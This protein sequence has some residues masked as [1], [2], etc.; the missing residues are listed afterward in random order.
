MAG[1][2][3]IPDT[4]ARHAPPDRDDRRTGPLLRGGQSL[5]TLPATQG[6]LALGAGM[7]RQAEVPAQ[8]GHD[9]LDAAVGNGV[10]YVVRQA[11]VGDALHVLDP[12]EHH[13]VVPERS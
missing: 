11:L 4:H 3:A 1:R 13:V 8:E 6:L 2:A 7:A 9:V 12:L 10:A 5:Q